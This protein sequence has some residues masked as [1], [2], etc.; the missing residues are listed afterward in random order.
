MHLICRRYFFE[1]TDMQGKKYITAM[2]NL[3][4]NLRGIIEHLDYIQN[5]GIDV[6]YMTPIFKSDRPACRRK[7]ECQPFCTESWLPEG[8]F[9][10]NVLSFYVE[11]D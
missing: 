9:K 3:H 1:F 6:L 7:D 5:L 4:G 10:Q 11:S 2:D 8:T